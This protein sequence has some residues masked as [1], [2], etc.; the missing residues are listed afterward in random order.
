MKILIPLFVPIVA[1]AVALPLAVF[2]FSAYRGAKRP[3]SPVLWSTI[4]LAIVAALVPN[5][6]QRMYDFGMSLPLIDFLENASYFFFV[7]ALAGAWML[8]GTGWKR[9]A[10]LVLV[11]VALFEPLKWTWAFFLWSVYGFAP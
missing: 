4:L 10:L 6:G 5:S 7:F 1:V 11:P 3:R 2:L 9:W 8:I